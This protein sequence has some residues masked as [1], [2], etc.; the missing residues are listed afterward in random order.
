[1]FYRLNIIGFVSKIIEYDTDFIPNNHM[2]FGFVYLLHRNINFM[3]NQWH[4][5]QMIKI[6]T[7]HIESSE[8]VLRIMLL[9]SVDWK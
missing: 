5:I 3:T 2:R 9:W 8:I 7:F 4:Y 6:C 1:M